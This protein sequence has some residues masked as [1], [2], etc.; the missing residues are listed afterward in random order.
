MNMN[1]DWINRIGVF[2][3]DYSWAEDLFYKTWKNIPR[4]AIQLV[5]NGRSDMSIQLKD[6]SFIKFVSANSN[7]CGRVYNKIYYQD[8]ISDE[9][10]NVIIRPMLR[11]PNLIRLEND[12]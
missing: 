7:S 6:G 8:G 1:I 2:Y 4:E 12:K 9:I 11:S 3:L 10:I 5:R